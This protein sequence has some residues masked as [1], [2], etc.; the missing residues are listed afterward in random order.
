LI[1]AAKSRNSKTS[2][3]VTG[4]KERPVM[5]ANGNRV[6]VEYTLS[7]DDGTV[8]TTNVGAEPF[9]YVQGEEQIPSALERQMEGLSVGDL[10]EITLSPDEA[11]G[12]VNP[13][14][15]RRVD[16]QSVPEEARRPGTLV[17]AGEPGD[18][19]RIARIHEVFPDHIVLDFN[20]RLAGERLTFRVRILGIEASAETRQAAQLD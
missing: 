12:P 2:G 20:H 4:V 19:T 8:V 14:E 7:L 10:R 3:F 9:V 16:I 15:F 11:Y 13:A 1:F 17:E 5:V 18:S 6:L